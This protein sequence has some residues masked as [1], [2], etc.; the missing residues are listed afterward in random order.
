MGDWPDGLLVQSSVPI[1]LGS[2]T[3]AEITNDDPPGQPSHPVN[4]QG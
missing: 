4:D 1:W 2:E 3:E